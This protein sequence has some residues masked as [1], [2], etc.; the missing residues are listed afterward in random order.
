LVAKGIKQRYGEHST[1]STRERLPP[2]CWGSVQITKKLC[3]TQPRLPKDLSI[4]NAIM[5]G[6]LDTYPRRAKRGDYAPA[7]ALLSKMT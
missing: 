6:V 1:A 7:Q 2:W 3:A 5:V 4:S